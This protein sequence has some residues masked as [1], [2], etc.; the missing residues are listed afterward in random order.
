M[1]SITSDASGSVYAIGYTRGD[2][3]GHTSTSCGACEDFFVVKYDSSG[4]KQWTQQLGTSTSNSTIAY[5]IATDSSSNVYVMGY[6]GGA[7]DGNT[8]AGSSD[9]FVLKYNSS[10]ARQWT[11]QLVSS[12]ND[13][14]K[15][16]ATDTIGNVYVTVVTYGALDGNT[17][18]GN[19]MDPD[20]FVVKYDSSGV[21]QWTKQLETSAVD[22]GEGIATDSSGNVYMTGSTPL[23]L[24]GNTS[25]GNQDLFVVKYDINGVKH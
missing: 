2:L 25:A 11:Q 5:G 13:Q 22:F 23:G 12:A 18:A 7:L 8:S 24:D 9:L 19:T 21:K 14:A 4:G 17:M 6:T 10:G 15:G 1:T 20:F 16:I 3:D